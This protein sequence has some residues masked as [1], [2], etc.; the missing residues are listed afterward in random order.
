MD[1]FGIL[2]VRIRR[3]IN[4]AIRDT[5]SSDPY[6]VVSTGDQR[7]KTRVM[8]GNCN[9]VWNEELSLSIKNINRPITLTVYDK[10]TF[11][12]DDPMGDAEFSMR[13]LVDSIRLRLEGLP[14]GT[15]VDRVQPS[16]SNC[17]CDES[18]VLWNKG[19]MTQD[20]LLRL[21]NV[22]CGKL[23]IQIEWVDVQGAKGLF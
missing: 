4:L 15:K 2:K 12:G 8:K 17:L 18:C 19:K 13:T 7:V 9:P 1:I 14:D 10:D 16:R 6:V 11:T 21:R 22:E 5:V 3:G 23:Q 20:M